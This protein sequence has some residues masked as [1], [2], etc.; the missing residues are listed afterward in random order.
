VVE[1][2][3]EINKD[4]QS[5]KFEMIDGKSYSGIIVGD[6]QKEIRVVENPLVTVEP[7]VLNKEDVDVQTK[8]T[9]SLMPEGLLDRLSQHEVM[10][11]IAFVLARGDRNHPLYQSGPSH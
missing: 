7:F 5:Y 6:T 2:S 3:F 8:S 9:K 1:P 10:D 11:L 4:Y